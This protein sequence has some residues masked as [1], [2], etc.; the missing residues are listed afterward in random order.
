MS[1]VRNAVTGSLGE[2]Q[3]PWDKANASHTVPEA[4]EVDADFDTECFLEPL[5]HLPPNIRVVFIEVV[6]E[7]DLCGVVRR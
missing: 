5:A 6:G 3:S 4:E 2:R 1:E 7:L